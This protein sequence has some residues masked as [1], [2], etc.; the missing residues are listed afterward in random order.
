MKNKVIRGSFLWITNHW[1]WAPDTANH[2][3]WSRVLKLD[4]QIVD[5][6]SKWLNRL[7]NN[8]SNHG[9]NDPNHGSQPSKWSGSRFMSEKMIGGLL[10]ILFFPQNDP[11]IIFFSDHTHSCLSLLKLE[12][13]QEGRDKIA[14][15]SNWI[16]KEEKRKKACKKETAG[17]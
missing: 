9:E 17:C 10:I 6:K 4:P 8:D 15:F 14:P 13:N 7:I 1:N 16:E 5:Q 11:W 3:Y 12:L 2:W